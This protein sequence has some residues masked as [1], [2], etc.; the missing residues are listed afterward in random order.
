MVSVSKG[1]RP[2]SVPAHILVTRDALGQEE[3][4]CNLCGARF[5]TGGVNEGQVEELVRT[6]SSWHLAYCKRPAWLE[7]V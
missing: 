2:R 6:W 1:K 5:A 4:E 7:D 3:F